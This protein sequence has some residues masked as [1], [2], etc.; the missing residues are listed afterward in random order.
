VHHPLP[1]PHKWKNSHC[2]EHVLAAN[3]SQLTLL[4]TDTSV[5][6]Q[7]QAVVLAITDDGTAA[8]AATNAAT[9]AGIIAASAPTATAKVL[10]VRRYKGSHSCEPT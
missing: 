8:A 2:Y 7:R 10:V 3:Q 5:T 1:L 6:E 4:R 9:V